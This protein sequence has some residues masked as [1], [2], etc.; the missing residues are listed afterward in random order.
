M[1][2]GSIGLKKIDARHA[3]IKKFFVK[4]SYRGKG[5]ARKLL[6]S[7][8]KSAAKHRFIYLY[9]GTVDVLHAAQR[10]YSKYGFLRIKQ[11]DLPNGFIKCELDTV[12]FKVTTKEL[13]TKLAEQMD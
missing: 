2:I 5:V 6:Y 9:L 11:S 4:E 13:Q 10:F 12:F 7:L 3:E 8:L 1:I